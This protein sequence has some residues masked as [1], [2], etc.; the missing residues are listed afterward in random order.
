MTRMSSDR[1]N[2]MLVFFHC[3]T[4]NGYSITMWEHVFWQMA[5]NVVGSPQRIHFAY[6]TMDNGWPKNLE[7]GAN[8]I[9]FDSRDGRPE[10]LAKI[11][12]YIRKHNIDIAMG[13]DQPVWRPAYKT[14][15]AAGIKSFLS[16]WGAPMSSLNHGWKLLAKKIEV[17][18]SRYQPDFYIFQNKGMSDTATHGRGVPASHSIIC[19]SGVN[20]D[21]YRP[22]DSKPFYAHEALG[23]PRERRIVHY[24]GH[25]EVRKGI[26]VI[27]GAA[28][29]LVEKRGRKDVHFVLVGNK[30]GV[31]KPFLE[32]LKDSP[33]LGHVTFGGYRADVND[34]LRSAYLG[35]IATT[36]W[37]SFPVS[38]MEMAATGLPMIVSNLPGVNEMVVPGVTGERF[39][40]GNPVALADAV[41]GYIDD[42][43]KRARHARG[44][45]D[46][47]V[48]TMTTQHLIDRLT[49]ICL[50]A[51][52]GQLDG[53]KPLPQLF[54]SPP[55]P[56][57]A[58]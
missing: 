13:F 16:Y 58:T 47:M 46:R 15:R 18:L 56:E 55:R 31:E 11:A 29:E 43:E 17:S 30:D 25:M 53:T 4:N 51:W 20:T 40:P 22:D 8:V 49:N 44:A 38:G 14:L 45:R 42:P 50:G 48:N 12:D 54:K 3:G 37:D 24:S 19:P 9:Q 7:Q 21:R 35:V 39:E 33:A 1:P 28:K 41:V 27:M 5:L 26:H 57:P 34:L 32:L 52:R 36:G 2:A 23:I 10:S 6:S